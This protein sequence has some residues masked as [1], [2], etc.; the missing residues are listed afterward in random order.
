MAYKHAKPRPHAEFRHRSQIPMPAVEEVEQ[1]LVA[2]LSPSLLA[3][4]QMERHDPRQPQ[5]VIRMR[6]RLLTLPVVVAIVVS[7]VWRRMPAVTEVQ[8]VLAREGLLWVTPVRVSLPA[9]TKRLDVLPAAV[10]GQLFAEVCA[11]LQA[12]GPPALPHPHWAPVRDAFSLIALVDGSTLEALRKKTQVLRERQ[13]L[14]LG[15]KMIVMV[16]AFSHRPLWQLYTAD[17]AANDKRFAAE[18]MAALPIGGLL[19]FD[20]G[21]FSFLWFDDFTDQ[22]KF[23]VTRMRAKIAYRTVQVLSQGPYYR[24]E[25][26]EVGQYRSHPCRHPLRM[27]S[28]LWQGGWY[29]Y[30]TNVLDPQVVSARQVCELYRRRWRIEDAF[31]LTKRVLDLAYLWTGSTNA[32]QLQIYA[33]LI[34]YAVLLTICQQVAQ[35]LGEPLERISVEMVF[36]ALYH[37][38]QAV[39]RGEY[40]DLLLFLTEHA[41]LLGIVKRRRKQHRERQHLESL[42]WGDP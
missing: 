8:R 37:Y 9:L 33:T 35:A 41:K 11:R 10:M 19:V 39:Q 15:G 14:V 32:V 21:F 13:G 2:L 40:D 17:A 16:E 1:Q 7:L 36:R 4:R 26:I 28:V 25:I 3:P 42:I 29:R 6:Q 23:F 30:L 38:G 5:R 27:I 24:D 20:L 31:A 12:Q 18:I 34:F 22:Q